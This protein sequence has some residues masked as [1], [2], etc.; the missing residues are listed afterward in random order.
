MTNWTRWRIA[1]LY[2][3]SLLPG[4]S[5]LAES[6]GIYARD[7]WQA[8]LG[9]PQIYS[10]AILLP[11]P[12][13]QHMVE[14]TALTV[15]VGLL[16][17]AAFIVVRHS[18]TEVSLTRAERLALWVYLFLCFV[19]PVFISGPAVGLLWLMLAGA[20]PALA[21][22]RGFLTKQGVADTSTR[23]YA[24]YPLVCGIALGVLLVLLYST[25]WSPNLRFGNDYAG[26]PEYTRMSDGRWVEN[27]SFL[28]ENRVLGRVELDPCNGSFTGG[29]CVDMPRTVFRSPREAFGFFPSGSGLH[30]SWDEEKLRAYRTPT[31]QECLLIDALLQSPQTACKQLL[32]KNHD[33]VQVANSHYSL[34]VAEFRQKNLNSLGAQ[35]FLERFFFHHA[36]LYLPVL[37][38]ISGVASD[39]AALPAQYGVGLTTSF[40][41]LLQWS[42]SHAFQDYFRLYWVGPGLYVVLAALVVLALTRRASL[43]VAT[44]ALIIGLLPFQT[45]DGLRLAPGSNPWRHLPDLLCFLAIGLHALRPSVVTVLLRASSIALLLW[46]NREFGIFML[47]GSTAWHLLTVM[48][49]PARLSSVAASVFAEFLGCGLVMLSLMG[50]T[51]TNELAF[52]NLL[53]VGAPITRLHELATYSVVWLLLI[54]FAA[55]ARFRPVQQTTSPELEVAGVGLCYAAFSSIYGLWNPSPGHFSVVWVCASLPIMFLTKWGFEAAETSVGISQR[56]MHAYLTI[57]LS[58]VTLVTSSAVALQT[59]DVFAKMFQNHRVFQWRLPGIT[60]RTTADAAPI[61]KALSLLQKEQPKGGVV[62]ISRY[63]VLLHTASGRLSRLPYVDLPSAVISWPVIDSI[64]AHINAAKPPVIF[65]DHDIFADRE[66]QLLGETGG[67]E[68]SDFYN[69]AFSTPGMNSFLINKGLM[70]VLPLELAA[71]DAPRSVPPNYHRVGHLAALSLLARQVSECYEPGPIGGVLQAWYRRCK[72]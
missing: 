45:I 52:Y 10:W 59:E 62:L 1:F 41:K 28:Q 4:L 9:N 20:L 65:M 39:T 58:A 48:Q 8:G 69:T 6:I 23:L 60:G 21:G 32:A 46:W 66:W 49:A 55:W 33:T 18:S 50:G 70:E 57:F 34:Q 22:T 7:L 38:A 67:F 13:I 27:N 31:D 54:G 19:L 17:S 56:W 3:A 40:A 47:A 35:E 29:L 43:A 26:L 51:G 44:A 5:A 36:Y 25:A 42:G 68:R 11:R 2:V 61:E 71:E 63:D 30:Y 53:G 14:Y 72:E 15:M 16:L 64:S 12:K 37:Q 24:A